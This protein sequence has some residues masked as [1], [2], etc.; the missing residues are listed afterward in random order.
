MI[1]HRLIQLF[2]PLP[3][4]Q[5][6]YFMYLFGV[7]E[8]GCYGTVDVATGSATLFVP[9]LPTEYAVWMGPLLSLDNFKTKYEV[10]AVH[11]ADEVSFVSLLNYHPQQPTN[12]SNI[13]KAVVSELFLREFHTVP[14]KIAETRPFVLCNHN[15]PP[16]TNHRTTTNTVGW[17]VNQLHFL[18]RRTFFCFEFSL[19]LWC[20]WIAKIRNDEKER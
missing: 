1:H 5:E 16:P 4:T 6:S 17:V 10:D 9:R 15:K 7:T 19:L 11:Y 3:K 13:W 20:F 18:L 12:S 2:F 8:P 14:A